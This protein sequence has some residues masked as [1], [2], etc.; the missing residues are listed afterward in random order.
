MGVLRQR[1]GDVVEITLDWPEVRNALGPS[2]GGELLDALEETVSDESVAAVVLSSSGKAFCAGGNLPEILKIAKQGPDAVRSTVYGVFQGI[3]RVIRSAP[4]PII[5]AVDGPAV[6]FG[7]DLAMA[8]N[9]TLM[10]DAGWIAQGWMKA[11]LI[12]ATGGTLYVAERGGEQAVWR[13]LA[14]DRV[15]ARTAESWGLAIACDDA[16][17]SALNMAEKLASY[18]REPLIAVTSLSRN[19]DSVAHLEEALAYQVGFLTG[20]VF[21]SSARKLLE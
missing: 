21:K 5:A 15:D 19:R 1:S 9:V 13:L 12:P 7:C 20:E 4:V 6:G 11:G 2:E 8:T 17:A 18:P 3:F 10:G 16:R 14:A